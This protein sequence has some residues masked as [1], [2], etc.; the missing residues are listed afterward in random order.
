MEIKEEAR[1]S[2]LRCLERIRMYLESNGPVELIQDEVGMV[3]REMTHV[4]DD[5]Q[6]GSGRLYPLVV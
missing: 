2:A 3:K 6:P 1:R 5:Q 4:V